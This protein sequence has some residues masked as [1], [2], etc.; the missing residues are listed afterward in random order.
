M[1]IPEYKTYQDK[2][3]A[4]GMRSCRR[5]ATT[6]EFDAWYEQES[7]LDTCVFRGVKE[8]KYKNYTSS[9]RKGFV[10]DR[11]NEMPCEM[12][13]RE[14]E[15]LKTARGRLLDAYC[16]TIGIPCSDLFLLSFAQHYGGISPLL[17]FTTRLDNA[18]FFMIDGC[19]Q[20]QSG[21]PKTD[22]GNYGSVY[23]FPKE[24]MLTI[25]QMASSSAN[26]MEPFKNLPFEQL[27]AQHVDSCMRL[28]SH[29]MFTHTWR[30]RFV[31]IENRITSF[32]VGDK[33]LYTPLIISNLNIVAQ[34]G[35]FVYSDK[36]WDPIEKGLKCV[37]IHKSLMPYIIKNYLQPKGLCRETMY[38]QEEEIADD[39]LFNTI[40]APTKH[41]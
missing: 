30:K 29:K 11:Q 1:R 38:P 8:A 20:D 7:K 37:D 5:I 17:D 28:F 3:K 27:Q 13:A 6:A 41:E 25:E 35:C 9:Q 39:A 10:E 18:L 14:I 2:Q 12:V 4:F 15:E 24:K 36:D 21:L 19:C 22:L 33:T 16:Q 32:N 23:S 34:Q 40:A 31:L 26:V